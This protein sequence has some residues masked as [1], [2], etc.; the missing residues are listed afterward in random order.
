MNMYT[1]IKSSMIVAGLFLPFSSSFVFA[2]GYLAKPESRS[3]ACKLNKNRQCGSIVWEPQSLE[4]P[5]NFP[6]AGPPDGKISSAN[7]SQFSSLNEQS[8]TRWSKTKLPNGFN[9]FTWVFT[10]SH[11]TQDWKYYITKNG[12]DQSEPLRRSSFD[13]NPFCTVDG[14][15]LTPPSQVTH[16]CSVPADR[17]GYHVIVAVW[18]VGNTANAFYNVVD[19]QIGEG[20]ALTALPPQKEKPT[21]SQW[22]DI[23]DINPIDDLQPNDRVSTRVF[24]MHGENINLKTELIIGSKENGQR[25]VWPRLLAEKINQEHISL[26]AG[27]K[28]SHGHIITVNG[29]NDIF[30]SANSGIQRVEIKIERA[31]T[32]HAKYDYVYPNNSK[33]YKAGTRVLA[34]D[35]RIYECK[36]FPYS[37]WCTIN[38]HQYRPAIGSH[39][40]DA[41]ILIK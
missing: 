30:T 33:N 13:L 20:T 29:K 17:K 2:H 28:S 35:Q 1:L 25:N 19:V 26:K 6:Q 27:V 11:I 4:A 15:Y 40:R 32:S 18:N 14:R 37:G 7:L 12:W 9:D 23:G 38:S 8:P 10:A 41:W 21:V 22:N 34:S 31:P 36:P 3:Y 16:R 5:K 24:D 39:W